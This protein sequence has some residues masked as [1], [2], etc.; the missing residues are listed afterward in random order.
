MRNLEDVFKNLEKRNPFNNPNSK[1]NGELDLVNRIGQDL[2]MVFDIGCRSNSLFLNL[3]AACHYFDPVKDFIDDL[4]QEKNNNKQSYFNAFGLGRKE[5]DLWYYPRYESFLNRIK[6]CSKNDEDNKILL[7]IKTAKDYIEKHNIKS[8]D[9]TKIDTEGYELSVLE[10]FGKYLKI[11]KLIQF[12]YGGT[13]IDS[14]VKLDE[15]INYLKSHGFDRFSY[16]VKNGTQLITKTKDHYRYCNI[17]CAN[18][19]L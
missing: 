12:E 1:T 15:I 16:L 4:S 7:K 10:G 19:N 9:F 8:I 5:E 14:G 13:F 2:K 3:N 11:I 6:S 17:I 18:T